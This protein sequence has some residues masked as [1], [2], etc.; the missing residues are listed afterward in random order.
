MKGFYLTKWCEVA[1]H[2]KKVE[3]DGVTVSVSVNKVP[4]FDFYIGF[5]NGELDWR[6]DAFNSRMYRVFCDAATAAS[7]GGETP[8]RDAL[9]F[10]LAY[11][12]MPMTRT[13]ALEMMVGDCVLVNDM[14]NDYGTVACGTLERHGA[15]WLVG[16]A[17]LTLDNVVCI[18]V[19]DEEDDYPL[20]VVV[21]KVVR[22]KGK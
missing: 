17:Y 3:D 1:V 19:H 10:V 22:K 8:I 7:H 2:G 16:T 12:G 6:I 14:S 5:S 9:F 21:D 20:S 4:G 15:G 18:S 11:A 13:R